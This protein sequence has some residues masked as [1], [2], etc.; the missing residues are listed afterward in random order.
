[1]SNIMWEDCVHGMTQDF[2]DVSNYNFARLYVDPAA[3]SLSNVTYSIGDHPYSTNVV[4]PSTLFYNPSITNSFFRFTDGI[5][6]LVTM[7]TRPTW[8]DTS[9]TWTGKIIPGTVA[10]YIFFPDSVGLALTTNFGVATYDAVTNTWSA[11]TSVASGFTTAA[12]SIFAA[13]MSISA[14]G[15]FAI[16]YYANYAASTLPLAK[17]YTSTTALTGWAN[18][19]TTNA[20]ATQTYYAQSGFYYNSST[21]LWYTNIVDASYTS[22]LRAYIT[23]TSVAGTYAAISPPAP[24]NTVT[25]Y[26]ITNGTYGRLCTNFIAF[27]LSDAYASTNYVTFTKANSLVS[28]HFSSAGRAIGTNLYLCPQSVYPFTTWTKV[29]ISNIASPILKGTFRTE[30]KTD[31]WADA[32]FG[33][34]VYTQSFYPEPVGSKLFSSFRGTSNRTVWVQLNRLA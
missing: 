9:A 17:L 26:I 15:E 20:T 29:D 18:R 8:A 21:F 6:A 1:M 23:S 27:N 7:A 11:I 2:S 4:Y 5:A 16:T 32:K 3:A 34:N 24:Y 30:Y 13:N 19:A 31:A 14:A 28:I 12:G 10:T 22:Y 25:P 33:L